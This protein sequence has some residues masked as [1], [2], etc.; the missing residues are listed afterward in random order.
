[1]DPVGL[2]TIE[3]VGHVG[4]EVRRPDLHVEVDH[5]GQRAAGDDHVVQREE[6]ARRGV[7]ARAVD[8]PAQG[9]PVL[10]AI[11]AAGDLLEQL[12]EL[13][14]FGLGQEPDLAEVDPDHRDLGLGHGARR[15]QERAVTAED[16]QDFD[17]RQRRE[18]DGRVAGGHGPALDAARGRTTRRPAPR[19]PTASSFVGL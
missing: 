19:A 12:L 2:A 7:A 1:M 11:P 14:G 3:P 17:C 15:P 6:R 8:R 10:E 4:G 5:A 18:E 9:H 13:V 16:D